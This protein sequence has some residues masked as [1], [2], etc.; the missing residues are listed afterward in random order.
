[1]NLAHNRRALAVGTA[2]TLL[3]APA[4]AAAKSHNA[5]TSRHP[6]PG[7]GYVGTSSE[8]AGKLG[9]PVALRVSPNGKVMTRFDIQWSSACQS[10]TG[11]G[12]YGGLS[13]TVNKNIASNG[14]FGDSGS[15]SR[16]F[17]GG[18]TGVFKV[19]LAGHFNSPRAA[20]GTFRVSV[21]VTDA[22]G[23]QTDACDSGSI[24]WV[25]FD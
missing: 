11:R 15:F 5:R 14:T 12:S 19:A 4:A 7:A 6:R 3:V 10:A 24:N 20:A 13:I 25:V 22:S 9:L 2:L 18:S 21:V 1:M 8:K 23:K 17:G 16:D